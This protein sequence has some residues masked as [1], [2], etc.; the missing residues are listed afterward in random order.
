MTLP[1]RVSVYEMKKKKNKQKKT[2]KVG[3]KWKTD[4]I[5]VHGSSCPSWLPA[6]PVHK[7]KKPC[8][9]AWAVSG[10]IY[11]NLQKQE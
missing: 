2:H 6:F 9:A 10:W 5:E 1:Y 8:S 4:S 7:P 3:E 11:S